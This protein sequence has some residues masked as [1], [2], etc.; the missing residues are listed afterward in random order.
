MKRWLLLL[1]ALTCVAVLGE[2]V[3]PIVTPAAPTNVPAWLSL[4]IEVIYG[5]L[6][7]LV[8]TVTGW[9]ALKAKGNAAKEAAVESLRVGVTE[10]YQTLYKQWKEANTDGTLTEQEKKALRENAISIA[11]KTATGA[12]LSCL[13]AWG[14]EVLH[15]LVQRIVDGL[16]KK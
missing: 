12:G 1:V 16:K 8:A 7:L 13:Q 15:S 10:T 3:L 14:P 2:E 5:G 4:V 9:L 6:G 11:K